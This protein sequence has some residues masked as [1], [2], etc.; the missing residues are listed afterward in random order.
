MSAPGA[1]VRTEPSRSPASQAPRPGDSGLGL[2]DRLGPVAASPRSHIS[3]KSTRAQM[4]RLYL[5]FEE[6]GTGV[7]F[8]T[9]TDVWLKE[10]T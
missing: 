7:L 4:T 1:C 9:A 8:A 2:Q 5:T 6:A 3:F 10:E